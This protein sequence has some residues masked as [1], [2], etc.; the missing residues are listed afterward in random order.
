HADI[1]RGGVCRLVLAG[2]DRPLLVDLASQ[3]V[4]QV[5]LLRL[6]GGEEQRV[7][8]QRL[9]TGED[10]TLERVGSVEAGDAILADADAVAIEPA[11]L[12]VVHLA[13][14]VGA[15]HEVAAPG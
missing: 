3:P 14:A 13:G 9:P 12:L 1:E 5:R 7:A 15:Q 11:A 6:A 4:R 2:A 8:L 10:D